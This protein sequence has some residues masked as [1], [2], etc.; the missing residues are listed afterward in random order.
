MKIKLDIKSNAVDSFNEALTKFE[1]AQNGDTKAYKFTILHLSHAIELVLKMYLQTLDENLVFSKCY[2]KVK[3]RA[4]VKKI[5]LLAAFHELEA[6]G[7]DFESV[8]KDHD[9][10]F[11]VIVSDVLAIAKN[12]KCGVTGNTFVDQNFIDDI[13]WMKGIR[14]AIEHFQVEFTAKEVRLCIG[15][16]VQGLDEFSDVFS[17]LNLEKEVGKENYE[18][19]KVL[20]D[21][22]E[23]SLEE[24]HMDVRE[25]K[26][27][28]FRG[29]RPKHQMFIE[30]NEYLCDSC[31]NETMIPND[32]S[33]T[34]YK[35]TY[36]DN[37]ESG[38]IEVDC[39]VCSLPW[40][41]EEMS[42]W[43]ENLVNV[44]PRCVNPEAW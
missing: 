38:Q 33:S 6:E 4:S 28:L 18:I 37:E 10:P 44:C 41:N 43:D 25:A 20:V 42:Y 35:C 19:F 34:G 13:N 27:A 8:I 26:D 14:N 22:Y 5:D 15:R 16:L 9:N 1:S 32:D 36:C 23:Q 30:W 24:A 29:T 39:D 12:E 3:Q 40:A 7:F 11:T 17:L 21:E 2:Q 31:G